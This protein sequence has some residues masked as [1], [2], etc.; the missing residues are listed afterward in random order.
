MISEPSCASRADRARRPRAH[1][2]SLIPDRIGAARRI[3][4]GGLHIPD[5][6]GAH[7][8][9]VAGAGGAGGLLDT[10]QALLVV[11]VAEVE[12]GRGNGLNGT[13]RR[14]HGDVDV[15]DTVA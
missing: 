5:D 7:G 15:G 14:G 9:V 13:A 8:T 4:S 11:G 1:R 6:V 10:G 2:D 12:L 3:G